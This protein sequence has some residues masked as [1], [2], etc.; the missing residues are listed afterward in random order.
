MANLRAELQWKQC[1]ALRPPRTRICPAHGA[2][3]PADSAP[4]PALT[5]TAEPSMDPYPPGLCGSVLTSGETLTTVTQ[6][7]AT[8]WQC[9]ASGQQKGRSKAY[10]LKSAWTDSGPAAMYMSMTASTSAGSIRHSSWR[11]TATCCFLSCRRCWP[12]HSSSSSLWGACLHRN[13][14]YMRGLQAPPSLITFYCDLI[15]HSRLTLGFFAPVWSSLT[16]RRAG[17]TFL[18]A[19]TARCWRPPERSLTRSTACD[20]LA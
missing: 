18:M 19:W 17:V 15:V 7:S 14:A 13:L 1:P 16:E 9:C 8:R 3:C 5:A 2:D 6:R 11:P 20:G 12:I 10:S 4:R